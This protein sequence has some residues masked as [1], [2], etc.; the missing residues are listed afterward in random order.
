VFQFGVFIISAGTAI[1]T[2]QQCFIFA[3]L[4]LPPKPSPAQ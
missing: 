4:I 1:R 3:A 2:E